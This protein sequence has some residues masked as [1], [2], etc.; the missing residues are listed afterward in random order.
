MR[1]PA[2]PGPLPNPRS[3]VFGRVRSVGDP[4]RGDTG[5]T[6]RSSS[7]VVPPLDRI[8][9][10]DPIDPPDRLALSA[11]EVVARLPR[12]AAAT[13]LVS[14]R[15]RATKGVTSVNSR[16]PVMPP[17][18][19][20][21]LRPRAATTSVGRRRATRPIKRVSVVMMPRPTD[22]CRV[23]LASCAPD[24]KYPE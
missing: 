22:P 5:R 6:S 3:T 23:S 1:T 11:I 17:P 15:W 21:R 2:D 10:V 7:K 13:S 16:D 8:D 18:R 19:V 12:T 24:L 20:L 14:S 9:L 4:C